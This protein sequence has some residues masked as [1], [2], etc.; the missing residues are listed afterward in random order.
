MD[1]KTWMETAKTVASTLDSEGARQAGENFKLG[2]DAFGIPLVETKLLGVDP[3]LDKMIKAVHA[4]G[5]NFYALRSA[6][7]QYIKARLEPKK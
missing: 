5:A 1:K 2:R 4:S 3:E 6:V 7:G